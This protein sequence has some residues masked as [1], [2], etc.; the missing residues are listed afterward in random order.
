MRRCGRIH[1]VLLFYADPAA[2]IWNPQYTPYTKDYIES[3][4]RHVTADRKHYKETDVTARKPGGDTEFEWR[5]KRPAGGT[6]RWQA[7]L[8]NEYRNPKPEWEY[9]GVRP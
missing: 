1:D 2:Q 3:E 7:D 5:V 9:K 8:E 6:A 4:Y